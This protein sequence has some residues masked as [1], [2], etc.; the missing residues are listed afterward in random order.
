[1]KVETTAP[2][3]RA[4]K[5]LS[6]PDFGLVSKALL[7]LPETFGHPHAHVGL[8]KLRGA[9]YELRAGLALRILFRR[10]A[11]TLTLLVLGTH[12]EIKRF[13]AQL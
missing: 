7:K 9:F 11:D 10:D 4:L 5:S 12:D 3:R 6:E 13:L 1:L 8:R 2:F